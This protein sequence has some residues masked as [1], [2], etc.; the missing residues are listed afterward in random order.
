MKSSNLKKLE[1][2]QLEEST[3]PKLSEDF[4]PSLLKEDTDTLS[5][6]R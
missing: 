4:L 6:I 5:E 1:K 2:L 3:L